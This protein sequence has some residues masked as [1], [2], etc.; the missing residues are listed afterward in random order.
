MNIVIARKRYVV[1]NDKNEIF[2]GLA[3]NYHFVPINDIK[4][5][6]LKTYLSEKKAVSSFLSSWHRSKPEDF[7]SGKY[8]VVGVV[9]SIIEADKEEE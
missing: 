9:E 4:D 2:C 8:S 3:R 5:A 6:P 7:E 1:V